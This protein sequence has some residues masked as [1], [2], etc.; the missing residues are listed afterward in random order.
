MHGGHGDVEFVDA[1]VSSGHAAGIQEYVSSEGSQ[2][3]YVQGC[4]TRWRL[5]K[6]DSDAGAELEGQFT[7]G[8]V[9]ELECL[10]NEWQGR[11]VMTVVS[12]RPG[13]HFGIPSL[14]RAVQGEHS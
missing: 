12:R 7:G 1:A 5:Q 11:D 14:R 4:E 13:R 2:R 9:A 8:E 3:R 10:E 6:A